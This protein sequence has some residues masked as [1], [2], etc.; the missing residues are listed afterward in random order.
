MTLIVTNEDRILCDSCYAEQ[1]D[2]QDEG[3]FMFGECV[4]GFCADCGATKRKGLVNGIKA[5]LKKA[6][7]ACANGH[8]DRKGKCQG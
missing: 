1:I 7:K 4:G 3:T 8:A 5:L 6:K 2:E